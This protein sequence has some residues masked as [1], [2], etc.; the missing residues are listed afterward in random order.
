MIRV[1]HFVV[2]NVKLVCSHYVNAFSSSF[3]SV[4]FLVFSWP[5]A[6]MTQMARRLNI[7]ETEICISR[8][9]ELCIALRKAFQ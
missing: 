6:F 4:K 9:G 1:T 3:P 8:V 5:A 7:F 2:A